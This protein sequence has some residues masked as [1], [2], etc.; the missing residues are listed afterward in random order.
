MRV[1][2]VGAGAIARAYAVLVSRAGHE[3]SMWAPRG[4][5]PS[6]TLEYGGVIEGRCTVVPLAEV[7]GIAHADAV[8]VAIPATAY[9]DVIPQ[10][11]PWLRSSQ[12]V[13]V[14]GALSL[15][16]LWLAELAAAHGE[17]PIVAASGTTVA[18]ARKRDGGAT[19]MTVRTRLAIATLPVAAADEA[20]AVLIQLFGE[21]F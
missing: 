21:R 16:P 19:I 2:I 1:A 4:Q 9:A 10:I 15:A 5:P 7:A 12:V 3:P 8:L 18:T 14:S 13:F 20:L 6:P 11:A 17:R